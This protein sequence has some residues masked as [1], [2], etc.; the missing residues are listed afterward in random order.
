VDRSTGDISGIAPGGLAPRRLLVIFNPAG[1]RA[2]RAERRLAQ[3]VAALETRGCTVVI[4]RTQG[5]GD[6]ERLAREAESEFD[7]LVAA[8]GD[9]TINEV[10]NGIAAARP[11]A[12]IPVGT[13]NVLAREIGLPFHP[14]RLAAVIA[15]GQAQPVWP[16]RAGGRLFTMMLGVGFDAA[17]LQRL[18]LGLKRRYGQPALVWAILGAWLRWQP[19]EF[20]LRAGGVDYRVASA[21]VAKGRL[22]AGRFVL[23]PA[24]RLA[25]PALHIVMLQRPGRL[26]MLLAVAALPL[27]L[28]HR[29]PGVE[30]IPVRELV[31]S[32]PD[33]GAVEIDGDLRGS[34]PL[35]VELAATPLLLVQPG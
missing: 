17:V 6:A 27:G 16:G 8:G 5:P 13:S 22:Y 29:L 35:A 3:V 15:E 23:A 1:G 11:L 10:V 31:L 25:D 18:D 30:I 20:R 14:R 2:A 34:L 9:G 7:V 24:A 32:G 33:G 19:Q 26:R 21:V 28:V 12:I 4:R